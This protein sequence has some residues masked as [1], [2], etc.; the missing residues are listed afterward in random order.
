M[1]NKNN[2]TGSF[3]R[4]AYTGRNKDQLCPQVTNYF[5]PQNDGRRR[6]GF[7]LGQGFLRLCSMSHQ[8]LKELLYV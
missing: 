4:D 2:K 8:P 7:C 1:K 5:S 3:V 6:F